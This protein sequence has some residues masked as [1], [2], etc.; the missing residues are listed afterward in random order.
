M[1]DKEVYVTPP[2]G[3]PN[4]LCFVWSLQKFLYGQKDA[5]RAW[6]QTFKAWMDST[7]GEV[8][9]IVISYVDNCIVT[10]PKECQEVRDKF[11]CYFNEAYKMT[12]YGDLTWHLRL[13]M[14]YERNSQKGLLHCN[15]EKTE[16]CNPAKTPLPPGIKTYKAMENNKCN[17]EQH[18][19]YH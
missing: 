16:N 17:E 9:L 2:E 12:D 14:S 13:G 7:L 19:L 11:L 18:Q 5:P 15:Q 3:V 1:G 10:C 6:H 8:Q 4:P